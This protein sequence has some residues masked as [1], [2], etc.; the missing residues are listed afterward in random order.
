LSG[1]ISPLDV[2]SKTARK[3]VSES[4]ISVLSEI[5]DL[6]EGDEHFEVADVPLAIEPEEPAKGG[7][8]PGSR[9]KMRIAAPLKM[10]KKLAFEKRLK[11][12]KKDL[13]KIM[14]E[15]EVNVKKSLEDNRDEKRVQVILSI[16]LFLA[17]V[18]VFTIGVLQGRLEIATTAAVPGLFILYPYNNLTKIGRENTF[19]YLLVPWIKTNLLPCDLHEDP[20]D[21]GECY[22][23]GLLKLNNWMNELQGKTYGS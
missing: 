20:K 3:L 9:V 22:R 8:G 18:A 5:M 1:A 14:A 16:I 19:L 10:R 6:L 2:R 23:N 15:L 4:T 11:K 13:N 21:V 17:G 12:V 7:R